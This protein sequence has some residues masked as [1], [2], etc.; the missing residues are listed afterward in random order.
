M[1]SYSDRD[2]FSPAGDWVLGTLRRNPEALLLMAAGCC[3][4]MRGGSSSSWS[5]GR[6]APHTRDK[7]DYQADRARRA[8]ASA[9]EGLARGSEGAADA[10][11]DYAS[12]VKERVAETASDYASQASDYASQMKDRVTETASS[13][14][15][16]V[17]D[18]AGDARRKMAERSARVT[19]QAQ[20]T[21]RSTMQRTL[22]EQ[23]LAVAVA[24]LAAG[25]AVAALFPATDI[26]HQAFGATHEKLREAASEAGQRVMEA[27]GKAGDRLK[28]VAQERGLTSEG[29]KDL[30]GEV[31]DTFKDAMSGN[32]EKRSGVTAASSASPTSSNPNFGTGQ[33]KPAGGPGPNVPGASPGGWS[34]R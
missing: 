34:T 20:A 23:P 14:V 30:A 8:S 15:D 25:A 17:A 24:G 9:R 5:G 32:S 22:R 11:D 16:S 31:T 1:S 21:L 13:Y 12:H 18:F 26:E 2:T 10:G 4:M 27:A 19:R 7:W 28:I 33:S 6:I 3:L 29:L